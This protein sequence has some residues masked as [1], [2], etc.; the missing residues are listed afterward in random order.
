MLTTVL[1]AS[2][3]EASPYY[4]DPFSIFMDPFE[5]DHPPCVDDILSITPQLAAEA[6]VIVPD[7]ELL[8][9]CLL[10]FIPML[11]HLVR[12]QKIVISLYHD[13]PSGRSN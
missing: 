8:E 5:L 6:L 4:P 2:D 13:A 3:R 1:E 12:G 9:S 7:V 11:F 10:H